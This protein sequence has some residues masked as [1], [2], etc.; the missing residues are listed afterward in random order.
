MKRLAKVSA[1]IAGTALFVYWLRVLGFTQIREALAGLGWGFLA[2][3]VLGGARESVRALAWVRT[4]DGPARLPFREALAARLAGEA[5]ATLVPMGVVIGEPAKAN[6]VAHRL[7]FGKAFRALMI[8][9][10]FYTASLPLL[11]TIA[12]VASVPTIA[13]AIIPVI[14]L[15]VFAASHLA[16]PAKAQSLLGPLLEF[17]RL[18]RERVLTIAA[19]EVSYHILAI[20]EVYVTLALLAPGRATWTSALVFETVN[21]G[22]TIVFKMLP[23]RVGVDEAGA[24]LVASR[25]DFSSATGVTVALVRKLRL[26]VWTGIGLL[27]LLARSSRVR[28]HVAVTGAVR[29]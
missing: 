11:F 13:A 19:F 21:R 6:H 20:F 28:G 3:A 25:F 2:I 17:G 22:I 18:H 24:A 29:G 23:M 1:P 7:P 9:F 8:E 27:I 5:I 16:L 15:V 4:I 26:L 10:A 12:A 14:A